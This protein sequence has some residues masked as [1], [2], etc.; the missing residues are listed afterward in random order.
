MRHLINIVNLLEKTYPDNRMGD[1]ERFRKVATRYKEILTRAKEL[2]Q[3]F[4]D[5]KINRPLFLSLSASI[6]KEIEQIKPYFQ[7]FSQFQNIKENPEIEY[8]MKTGLDLIKFW[9]EG[10]SMSALTY[11]KYAPTLHAFRV[12]QSL[13]PNPDMIV[14]RVVAVEDANKIK[15]LKTLKT[16]PRS[17]QSWTTDMRTAQWFY[18]KQYAHGDTMAVDKNGFIIDIDMRQLHDFVIIKAK[19]SGK[20]ILWT[21]SS[22]E[23]LSKYEMH[24]VDSKLYQK[25]YRLNDQAMGVLHDYQNENEIIVHIPYNIPIPIL[26]IYPLNVRS[27]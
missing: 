11:K 22:L 12:I 14:F 15:Y 17:L 27:V 18:K 16:G 10:W 21:P 4:E 2:R 20:N 25:Y 8:L 23:K 13:F 9:F 6:Q 3:Y 1:K 19:I 24:A 5:G 7:T 26:K